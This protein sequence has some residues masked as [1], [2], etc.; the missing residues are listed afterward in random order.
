MLNSISEKPVHLNILE[1]LNFWFNKALYFN[2]KSRLEVYSY[3]L[4]VLR[5][6]FL[7]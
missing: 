3:I 1:I 5:L 7:T 4:A 6:Q 2:C